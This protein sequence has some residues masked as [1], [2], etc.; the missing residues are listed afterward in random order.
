MGDITF[1][2]TLAKLGFAHAKA[3]I[4]GRIGGQ[5]DDKSR[6]IGE[7]CGVSLLG[8]LLI[9][10]IVDRDILPSIMPRISSSRQSENRGGL[11][12]TFDR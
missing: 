2:G 5:G 8:E 1:R 9:L 6:N 7:T 12:G 3:G 4:K 11:M 10:V